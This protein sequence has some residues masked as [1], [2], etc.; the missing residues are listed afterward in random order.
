MS[1]VFEM[2]TDC[3]LRVVWAEAEEMADCLIVSIQRDGLFICWT[4][5]SATACCKRTE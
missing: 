4:E 1:Q 5:Q 3:I 2:E